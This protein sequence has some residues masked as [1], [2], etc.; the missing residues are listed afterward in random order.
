M[1]SSRITISVPSS[2]SRPSRS[3]RMVVRRAAGWRAATV[4]INGD[5]A[6]RRHGPA[7]RK[8][9]A[10]PAAQRYAFCATSR[11]GRLRSV[12]PSAQAAGSAGCAALCLP[13][14]RLAAGVLGVG[15]ERLLDP[16]Q[17]VVLRHTIAA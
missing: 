5:F 3:Q 10:R 7:L 13:A 12:M 8:Q 11:L 9:P 6:A 2:A 14:K 1:Y 16:Q 4:A 15:A 17:L